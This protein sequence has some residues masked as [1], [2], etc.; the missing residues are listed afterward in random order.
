MWEKNKSSKNVRKKTKLA[1]NVRKISKKRGENEN[2]N[3]TSVPSS[4]LPRLPSQGLP[5]TSPRRPSPGHHCRLSICYHWQILVQI[6]KKIKKGSHLPRGLPV[7]PRQP[8]CPPR[9]RT[10]TVVRRRESS[11]GLKHWAKFCDK[12]GVRSTKMTSILNRWRQWLWMVEILL[13]NLYKMW[14]M[15]FW[16]RCS[17]I[18]MKTVVVTFQLQSR[19]VEIW[20]LTIDK[21]KYHWPATPSIIDINTRHLF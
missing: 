20:L 18:Q 10:A 6:Q 8:S 1:K 17:T 15:W 9:R 2:S 4:L 16:E 14:Q 13:T 7:P 5:S 19:V 21:Y 3:C 12:C 11:P